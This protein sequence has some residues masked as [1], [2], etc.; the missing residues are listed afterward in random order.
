M[1]YSYKLILYKLGTKIC[2]YTGNLVPRQESLV[3]IY[4][5]LVPKHESLVPKHESLVPK[6][7]SM[8]PKH[9]RLL[10]MDFTVY[11]IR[12]MGGPGGFHLVTLK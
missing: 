5:S 11:K 3:P 9:E 7:E 12:P 8:V 6:Y 2:P 1:N 4:E 10:Q